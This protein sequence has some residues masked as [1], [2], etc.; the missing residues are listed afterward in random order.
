[1]LE[2]V[3]LVLRMAAV[4]STASAASPAS[5]EL[6]LEVRTV[7]DRLLEDMQQRWYMF[8]GAM[9]PALGL[10]KVKDA[11]ERFDQ[12]LQA[13]AQRV[14][15]ELVA[16]ARIVEGKDIRA[17]LITIAVDRA[18][19]PG[20]Y[21][22]IDQKYVHFSV[23]RETH[24]PAPPLPDRVHSQDTYR[25]SWEY[26][27]LSPGF[28]V[29]PGHAGDGIL[30][31]L[32]RIGNPA[33]L[34]SLQ[35]CYHMTCRHVESPHEAQ[36]TQRYLLRSVTGFTSEDALRMLLGCLAESE[37]LPY[38]D[39]PE[40][41]EMW[42]WDDGGP[43]KYVAHLLCK[44]QVRSRWQEVLARFDRSAVPE[45][46]RGILD[47]LRQT[48]EQGEQPRARWTTRLTTRASPRPA[49]QVATEPSPRSAQGP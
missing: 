33:T 28:D 2:I 26:W 4:A 27:L 18:R 37:H 22:E 29:L 17:K 44:P 23:H 10:Q 42:R 1:M 24:V 6:P 45:G 39:D 46:E 36:R 16:S 3:V 49:T 43:D 7:T 48:V 34:L 11:G 8:S 15:P 9:D 20:V 41:K 21:A 32:Q 38:K 12:D 19:N 13:L 25:L 14:P 31:A 30:F 40:Y 5:I 47:R 35:Y